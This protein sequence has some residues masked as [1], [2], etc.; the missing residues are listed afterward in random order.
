LKFIVLLVFEFY[1]LI[2][3]SMKKTDTTTRREFIAKTGIVSLGVAFGAQTMSAA[4]YK[5]I[6]GAN[7]KIRTGFIGIGN[8][9]S[10][11]LGLFMMEQ[12]CEVAA[13]CDIYE[14]YLL[15]DRSKVDL[16]YL[17]DLQGQ[18]P[19]MGEKFS[20]RPVNYADYRKL[21]EDKSIDAVCIATPDHWHAIQTIEAVSA[22]KDVYVEKPLTATISEG[23]AMVNAQKTTNRVVAVGLNRRGNEAYQKLAK[24]I[25]G[26]KIGKIS[27]ARAARVGN[28]FPNGIGKM[29]AEQPPKD[30]NWDMWLGPRAYRPYQ[31][32]IAPYKFR[33]WSDFSSQMGNWGVHYMDAI[34]WMMGEVAPASITAHGGKY[35]LDHD[36]DIPDTMQVTFEFASKAMI[37]FSIYE[38]TS[39]DL[40]PYGELELKGTK[41][42]VYAGQDGYRIIPTTNGQFQKWDKFIN[43][44]EFNLPSSQLDD[45]SSA[46]ATSALIRNFLD[47]IKSRNNP[48]CP[49]EEGHRSTSF[50]HLAN[51]SLAVKQ[52]LEWD[53]V[54]ER[55]T[56]SEKAN[57]MLS[58][59]YRKP[60]KI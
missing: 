57:Q 24:V 53:S 2:L 43:K 14:P 1:K 48:L 15:R 16:R 17:Q 10:Q 59:E 45:G 25:S 5:R 37:S 26:G 49:L 50:A 21:L 42:T 28:M 7:E 40:F 27:V 39:G 58:Y 9:G 55:F 22:G 3:K 20:G 19:K 23:R 13:L 36:G 32:N 6:I 44:E 33:W 60:W 18:V 8:R 52:R 30:F 35:V 51:I 34:R 47:C 38:A 11:L 29:K 31:Y 46:S 54:N 4:S 56:N 41:G 12:D